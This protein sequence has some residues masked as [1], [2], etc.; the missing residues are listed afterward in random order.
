MGLRKWRFQRYR[1]LID[2]PLRVSHGTR[3]INHDI[4]PRREICFSP[5]GLLLL[6]VI[7]LRWRYLRVVC[8]YARRYSNRPRRLCPVI[9]ANVCHQRFDRHFYRE[10]RAITI[11][12]GFCSTLSIYSHVNL[13]KSAF[14]E[15]PT[16]RHSDLP[17]KLFD[18][19]EC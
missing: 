4:I 15:F 18:R 3:D 19:Y 10:S 11:L 7:S 8:S 1:G 5:Q 13:Q 2:S 17:V 9:T 16:I 6:A 14:N 12:Y